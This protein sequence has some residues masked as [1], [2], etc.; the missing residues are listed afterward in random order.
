VSR[1][2]GLGRGLGSLIPTEA[3]KSSSDSALREVPL[4][5]IKAN[6][7]Q[8]RKEFDEEAL[9]SLVDSIKAIGVLQPVLLREITD[10][11]FEL[12]AGERRCRAARR[13]GLQMIPAL[14]QSVDDQGSLE[15]AL[16][17]NLHRSDLNPLD[18]AAGYQQ[19]IEEFK[20]THEQ[21][22][23]RVGKSRTV[24]SNALRLFQLPATVLRYVRD[25]SI[26][27]GHARALLSTPDRE[28]QEVLA[29]RVVGE[30]LSVRALEEILREGGG[31]EEIIGDDLPEVGH[32][33]S[34]RADVKRGVSTP[35]RDAGILELEELL[36]ERLSTRVKVS[37][38]GR[39]G[40]VVIDFA[41][42]E[43]L[44]RIYRTMLGTE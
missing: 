36:A 43:D 34:N 31:E 7:F 33:S 10:G 12:I 3:A 38:A 44:E 13:A 6:P 1:R 39:H 28:L 14:V 29:Q 2:S 15:R 37:L 21:V 30:N 35:V 16:V 40:K 42:I 5:L 26:S 27:A 22:A 25:G 20:M 24:I 18:E 4:A 32:G 17:E 11:K 19:M 41:T 8:P 23:Q 9:S